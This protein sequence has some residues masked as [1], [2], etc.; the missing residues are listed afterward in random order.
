MSTW[1][2]MTQNLK[3]TI[4][5]VYWFKNPHLLIL[6]LQRTWQTP[7][8]IVSNNDFLLLLLSCT[9]IFKQFVLL[10][11][12][13]SWLHHVYTINK[14]YKENIYCPYKKIWLSMLL[15]IFF[16]FSNRQ[17]H[18][19][20]WSELSNCPRSWSVNNGEEWNQKPILS[21]CRS[22]M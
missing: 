7:Y 8:K 2:Y 22:K 5:C 9:L 16:H 18:S 4:L 17:I 20:I 14:V 1:Y 21:T 15:Q 10:M 11:C 12:T 19:E 6:N 13:C 3:E